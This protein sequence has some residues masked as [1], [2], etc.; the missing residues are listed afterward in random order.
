MDLNELFFIILGTLVMTLC[1]EM[2]MKNLKN[3]VF[4]EATVRTNHTIV[5][6]KSE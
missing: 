6:K 3:V 5:E 4:K 2:P 1:V